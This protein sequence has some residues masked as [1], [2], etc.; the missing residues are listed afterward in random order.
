M[1][2]K[3]STYKEKYGDMIGEVIHHTL[4]EDGTIDQ[5][6]KGGRVMA[7]TSLTPGGKAQNHF[8][9]TYNMNILSKATPRAPQNFLR[10]IADQVF[11]DS[12]GI[13]LEGSELDTLR[14]DGI[15]PLPQVAFLV[16]DGTAVSGTNAGDNIILE[17]STGEGDTSRMLLETSLQ[18]NFLSLI[19]I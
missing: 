12:E 3:S 15:D 5:F 7:E 6:G 14:L 13:Q 18:L 4:F 19:D 16:L 17:S 2:W 9:P 8:I 10:T 1:E 11:P